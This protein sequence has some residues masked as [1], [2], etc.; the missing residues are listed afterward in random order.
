MEIKE[1]VK[2]FIGAGLASVAGWYSG[3]VIDSLANMAHV[4]VQFGT[5]NAPLVLAFVS[6]VFVIFKMFDNEEE[7]ELV[8]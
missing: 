1:I 5:S 3:I 4:A 8:E 7:D 6:G 2:G